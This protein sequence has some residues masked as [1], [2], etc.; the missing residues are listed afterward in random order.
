MKTKKT[1]I[2]SP[3]LNVL[4]YDIP[5]E[6]YH[7]TPG[8]FSSSQLKDA[9]DDIEFFHKKWI[10]KS[11]EREEISAFSVGTY[12]HTGILEPH[13][14]SKDCAVYRNPRRHGAEWE[15]F[16]KKH[17]GKA[18]VNIRELESAERLIK[19]VKESTVA[20]GRIN[21]SES[22]VSVFVKL[23]VVWGRIYVPDKNLILTATGWANFTGKLP[24]GGVYIIVKARADKLGSDFIL[25]LKSTTGNAKSS[26]SMREKISYY[27]YELSA[28]FYLDLFSVAL[29]KQMNTFIWTFA[30]KDFYNSRSY[31]ASVKNILIGRSKWKKAILAIAD[32]I[33]NDWQFVDSMGT[34][35]PN[36][37]EL[38]WIEETAADIL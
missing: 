22:E 11:I 21:R 29:G 14:L 30:S 34:L 37:W 25:D 4:H 35:E 3:E 18:I 16:K 32:G 9:I 8:T 12:F 10:E 26:K 27:C 33:A 2:S 13:K 5:S 23:Y 15:A 7:S 6:E 38:E 20:M 19:A 24:K 1:S 28:A 17:A 36:H 31:K